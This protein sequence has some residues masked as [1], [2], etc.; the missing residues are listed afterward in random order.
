MRRPWLERVRGLG[1][2]S[3]LWE[4]AGGLV[5]AAVLVLLGAMG[6]GAGRERSA[7][8]A[9][10]RELL[11]TTEGWRD[12]FVAP[13][14][15]ESAAWHRSVRAV[16]EVEF[17]AQARLTLLRLV[18]ERAVA[19]GIPEPRIAFVDHVPGGAWRSAAGWSIR[20]ADYGLR[21]TFMGDYWAAVAFFGA[22]PPM[23]EVRSVDLARSEGLVLAEVVLAVY[24]SL[25]QTPGSGARAGSLD[26]DAWRALEPYLAPVDRTQPVLA[27][28]EM[29]EEWGRAARD[30]FARTVAIRP[31]GPSIYGGEPGAGGGWTVSA[32]M[33]T[34][35]R[36][37][38]V[39][40]GRV[41]AA[42][43]TI[44]GGARV[45]S[46]EPRHVVVRERGGTMRQLRLSRPGET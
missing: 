26:A 19:A 41:V 27:R 10:L 12:R 1:S 24:E 45:A 37:V 17:E 22:L 28:E 8:A 7:H 4:V 13:V 6:W 46:V 43:D 2:D 44:A 20:P 42:G 18:S 23:V 39:I 11:R 5:L 9:E 31:P 16:A 15:A 29:E 40:D 30:P 34:D 35:R 3:R 32:I 14:P 33:I 38:A 36:R 21:V 25:V